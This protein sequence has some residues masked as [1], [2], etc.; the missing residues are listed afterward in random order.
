MAESPVLDPDG[1]YQPR[2]TDP[3][4][5][6]C[7]LQRPETME[8]CRRL[9]R[10]VRGSDAGAMVDWPLETRRPVNQDWLLAGAGK[11]LFSPRAQ[12]LIDEVALPGEVTWIPLTLVTSEGVV[13]DHA[14]LASGPARPDIFA[15]AGSGHLPPRHLGAVLV[16]AKMGQRQVLGWPGGGGDFLVVG[17]VLARLLALSTAP[18]DLARPPFIENYPHLL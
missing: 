12:R 13:T 10:A 1:W 5:A 8:Y 17:S 11:H 14:V 3:E 2:I 7:D 18:V 16:R 15:D 9:Y 6:V 4:A